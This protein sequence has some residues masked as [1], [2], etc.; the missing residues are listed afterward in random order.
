[1]APEA[2]VRPTNESLT[3]LITTKQPDEHS[4]PKPANQ[5]TSRPEQHSGPTPVDHS[6]LKPDAHNGTIPSLHSTVQPAGVSSTH[7]PH[8][9]TVKPKS[10][11][12]SPKLDGKG[13]SSDL[14]PY[15]NNVAKDASVEPESPVEPA[16][17]PSEKPA[18]ESRETTPRA[19]THNETSPTPAA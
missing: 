14:E 13:R 2:Q 8:T 3:N 7:K 4:T 18:I 6:T 11:T 15:E 9:T 5:S 12:L 19:D 16:P 10:T 17:E 1:V